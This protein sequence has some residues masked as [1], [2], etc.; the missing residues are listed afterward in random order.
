MMYTHVSHIDVLCTVTSYIGG[1][2]YYKVVHRDAELL[3][4]LNL[5]FDPIGPPIY[6]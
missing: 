5:T 1:V 4:S 6:I 3:T 2:H